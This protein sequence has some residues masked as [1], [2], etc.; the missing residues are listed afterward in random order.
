VRFRVR[1]GNRRSRDRRRRIRRKH[2]LEVRNDKIGIE[3]YGTGVCANE[4]APINASG[5]S[6]HITAFERFEQA[7]ADLRAVGNCPQRDAASF[8][9]ALQPRSE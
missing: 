4:R 6:R 7:D 9:F 8:P 5:P 2:A 1:D 3:P